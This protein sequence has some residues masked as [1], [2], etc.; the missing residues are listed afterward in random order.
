MKKV[1]KRDGSEENFDP[2][3][4]YEAIRKALAASQEDPSLAQTIGNEVIEELEKHPETFK[5][6]VEDI[7]DLIE[8]ILVRYGKYATAK[9]YIIYRKKRSEIREKKIILGV[10]DRLKLSFN[11]LKVLE[12]RYLRRD[13]SGRVIESPEQLFRRVAGAIAEVDANYGGRPE[14][15]EEKFFNCMVNLEFLPNSPTLMNAGT[16][17]DQLSACFVLPID[18]SLKSIFDTLKNAALIHQSGGG[19]GFSFSR[20]RPRGDVVKSTMGIASGPISFMKIFDRATEIIK[21]GGRRRGANMGVLHIT[22][23]DIIDFI[24]L[25]EKEDELSN[26]NISVAVSDD[27]INRAINNQ[28]YELINP[29]DKKTVKILNARDVFDLIITNAWKVGDPGM[30]YIDEINRRNPTLELGVIE[31]TNPCGEVPLLPNE[32]CNLGSINLVRMFNKGKFDYNKLGRTIEVAIHFLDNVIDAN[33]YIIKEIETATRGNRKIGLG[34]MGFADCL[35]KMN[36]PYDSQ[37]ALNFADELMN[38]IQNK[39]RE[40]SQELA[41]KRGSFP[42]IQHSIFRNK[43]MRNATVTSIAPTGTIST[44]AD[45]SS[46]IEPL[47]SVAYLRNA[48][49]T[50]LLTINPLFEKISR[51]K[52]FY[53][54]DLIAEIVRTGSIRHIK[55]IPEEVRRIF[56]VAHDIPPE[57]HIRMQ[58]TFQHYVDNAVSKTI[59]LPENA[60]LEQ[61][62]MVF[63]LAHQLKCKGTTI[64]RY[65]SKKRQ[66]LEFGEISDYGVCS[67]G[68][69]DF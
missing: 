52:G 59:N 67:S 43:K 62:R 16:E 31:T 9:A 66:A 10:K 57:F 36:I 25:K 40:V 60:T 41:E 46:G 39:A 22:H 8:K 7:Q 44:I 32:S 53:S 13:I 23:P 6:N 42:N 64:Y 55:Q 4:I 26:F 28:G 1:I 47:F 24:R 56:P 38:F 48:L 15:S 2:N 51:D 12:E 14:E 34:I 29:R 68:I 5:P 21:Q 30:L 20:I 65:G 61:T 58:A 37:T 35:I 18:D 17:M 69:C 49:D 63:L 3:R 33:R 54:A 50:T 19:T 11:S 27:F 45:V